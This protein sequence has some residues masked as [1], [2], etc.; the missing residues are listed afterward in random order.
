MPAFCLS[1]GRKTEHTVRPRA[2]MRMIIPKVLHSAV[3]WLML[4]TASSLL[5]ARAAAAPVPESVGGMEAVLRKKEVPP[6][7]TF[8]AV[9]GASATVDAAEEGEQTNDPAS[10]LE[11]MKAELRVGKLE[12][13]SRLGRKVAYAMPSNAEAVAL[14][15]IALSARGMAADAALAAGRAAASDADSVLTLCALAMVARIS[16][17]LPEAFARAERATK[18]DPRHPYPWNILGRCH[19]DRADFPQAI[20][21]FSKAVELVPEF[22]IGYC[23]LGA[24]AQATGDGAGAAAHF[25]KALQLDPAN[26]APHLGMAAVYESNG[27]PE[28][29]IASVRQALAHSPAHVEALRALARL[30]MQA[31]RYREALSAATR[32]AVAGK[33]DGWL[34]V[35]D[36]LLHLGESDRTLEALKNAPAGMA[37]THYLQGFCYIVREDYE[38]ALKQMDAVLQLEPAHFGG[39]F[40]RAVL[41]LKT[42]KPVDFGAFDRFG[43][44]YAASVEFLRGFAH[45]A[46]G[47]GRRA[48]DSFGNTEDF[49]PGW[50]ARGLDVRAVDLSFADGA[51]GDIAVGVLLHLRKL[52]EAALRFFSRALA[53]SPRSAVAHHWS[54]MSCLQTGDRGGALEHFETATQ[55]APG[56][57][58]PLFAAGELLF[59]AGKP[60]KAADYYLRAFDA[61]AESGLALR[62]G[63]YYAN[64]AQPARA[65]KY[66]RAAI[67]LAP[68]FFAAYNQLAW[69][70]AKDG[71]NLE[72]ALDLARKADALQPGNASVLDTIAWIQYQNRD[73]G[74]A[75]SN[76]RKALQ[77]NAANPTI[78]FH[79]G[80]VLHADGRAEKAREALEKSLELSSSFEAADQARQLLNQL[81]VL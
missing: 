8:D 32:M 29:A 47:D 22:A 17:N 21:C 80:V 4:S 14:Y 23:N 77:A 48:L 36:A 60:E 35:A 51:T 5:F 76:L 28:R 41:L 40:A 19:A 56:F 12:T 43:A 73:L 70:F 45:A 81:R 58:S 50:S 54:G 1:S 67:A 37:A 11:R 7:I 53:R 55:L 52:P 44:A 68:K 78:W 75:E 64:T 61:R 15:S 74:G 46:A 59:T 20:R 31:G 25:A 38:E 42:G 33:P 13:S 30:E 39:A 3:C 62:L 24:M 57:F 49:V 27:Q 65:E 18:A 79:L 9:L 2:V 16:G 10:A 26:P 34:V 66:L 71:R 63:V 6:A 69:E 72:E